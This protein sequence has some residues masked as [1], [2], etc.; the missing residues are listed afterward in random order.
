MPGG[1]TTWNLL[2]T[3]G[4]RDLISSNA[5]AWY[6]YARSSEARGRDVQNG[7][8]RVVVGVD[9][10]SS[11][12]IAI[13][14]CNTGQTASY[15]FKHDPIHTYKWDFIGGGSGRVGPQKSEIQE[16]VENNVVPQNQCVFA[17]TINFTL[18][19]KTWNDLPSASVQQSG[20]ESGRSD[21]QGPVL[22]NR[23]ISS[24]GHGSSGSGNTF[25][26]HRPG[27][28]QR[29]SHYSEAVDFGPVE[30]GV[31]SVAVYSF[32]KCYTQISFQIIHPSATLH[33]YL[34]RKVTIMYVHFEVHAYAAVCSFQM[35]TR[36]SLKTMT[37]YSF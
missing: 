14:A 30:L 4:I 19:G 33:D 2:K 25:S 36:L 37:G 1:A 12:G 34:H 32:S 7:G 6:T 35:P 18:S 29:S 15:V 3:Q 10:V 16:L 26:G 28:K 5:E 24:G 27:T 22:R 11:W 20:S 8:I 13:S 21:H 9:K 23:E 31:S 17:R